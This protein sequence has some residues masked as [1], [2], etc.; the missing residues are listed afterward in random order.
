MYFFTLE[1]EHGTRV[2]A[3]FSVTPLTFT[4]TPY[5]TKVN[6][7]LEG[8]GGINSRGGDELVQSEMS[9]GISRQHEKPSPCH[10]MF[11]TPSPRP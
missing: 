10:F 7:I 1:P 6:V 8:L 5:T 2:V 9:E 11:A 3:G 4:P